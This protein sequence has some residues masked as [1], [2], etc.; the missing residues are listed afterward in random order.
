M[1]YPTESHT[2]RRPGESC[3]STCRL[4]EEIRAGGY[5]DS[6]RTLRRHIARLDTE[7]TAFRWRKQFICILQLLFFGL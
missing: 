1:K 7:Q 4:H 2:C 5:R 6:L 3:L